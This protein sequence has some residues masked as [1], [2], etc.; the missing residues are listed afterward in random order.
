M[1]T[2]PVLAGA[3]GLVNTK[4]VANAA[5]LT[6]KVL[7][8]HSPIQISPTKATVKHPWQLGIAPKV[9]IKDSAT[10]P[11]KFL[12]GAGWGLVVEGGDKTTARSLLHSK[13]GKDGVA[14]TMLGTAE[15]GKDSFVRNGYAAAKVK[16]P[17]AKAGNNLKIAA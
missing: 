11:N 3:A 12:S 1:G 10:G 5:L 8:E 14:R 13:T 9:E 16:V 4:N 17:K 7:G 15:G 2:L 6:H